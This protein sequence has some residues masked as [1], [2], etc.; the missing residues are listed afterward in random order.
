M[1]HNTAGSVP[2][3]RMLQARATLRS[4]RAIFTGLVAASRTTAGDGPLD[5][6]LGSSADTNLALWL[7]NNIFHVK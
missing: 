7:K 4:A 2:H 5:A 3:K 6:G 1:D